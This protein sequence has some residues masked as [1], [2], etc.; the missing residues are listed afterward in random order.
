MP[1]HFSARRNR[2]SSRVRPLTKVYPANA[3]VSEEFPRVCDVG[4]GKDIKLLVSPSSSDVDGKQNGHD[5][6]TANQAGDDGE[7]EKAEEEIR[8]EVLVLQ[9]VGI[10]DLP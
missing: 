6:G 7:L 10:W 9:D 1:D 5:D 3:G 2:S 8:V 4:H